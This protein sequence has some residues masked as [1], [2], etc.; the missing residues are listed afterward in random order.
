MGPLNLQNDFPGLGPSHGRDPKPDEA[1]W[2]RLFDDLIQGL[3]DKRSHGQAERGGAF[4]HFLR[5]I[6]GHLHSFSIAPTYLPKFIQF[7]TDWLQS[8]S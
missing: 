3:G 1:R 8:T 2:N 6:D 5:D 4:D 7:V